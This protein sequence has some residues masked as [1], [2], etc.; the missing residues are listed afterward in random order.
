MKCDVKYLLAGYATHLEV[1][2]Y[3][4][5]GLVP[6]GNEGS[7]VLAVPVVLLHREEG[8]AVAKVQPDVV[9]AK[10]VRKSSRILHY[11]EPFGMKGSVSMSFLDKYFIS[12]LS[13]DSRLTGSLQTSVMSPLKMFVPPRT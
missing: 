11:S 6:V 7:L 2:F 10:V 5:E 13:L 8:A 12:N 9:Q 3:L 1:V 4:W